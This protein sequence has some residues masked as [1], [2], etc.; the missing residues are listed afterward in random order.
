[1]EGKEAELRREWAR[2]TAEQRRVAEEQAA[3][4]RER[5]AEAEAAERDL[6]AVAATLAAGF[7]GVE[8]LPPPAS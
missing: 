2:L 7:G 5:A 8:G 3:A 4:E 6:L 1:M